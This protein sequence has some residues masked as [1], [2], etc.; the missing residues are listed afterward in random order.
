MATSVNPTPLAQQGKYSAVRPGE[1]E[2][3]NEPLYDS[4]T[5]AAAGTTAQYRLFSLPIGQSGKTF[6]DTNMELAGQLSAGIRFE[7]RAIELM[8][9]PGV[10]PSPA[11]TTP[12]TT[13]GQS[14][15]INDVWAIAKAGYLQF[16][17]LAKPYLRTGPLGNFPS[18]KRLDV[19][20]A[21]SD[22]TTAGATQMN[23]VAYAS[24]GG[25]QFQI[26]PVLLDPNMNFSVTLNFPSTTALPSTQDAKIF[27]FLRGIKTR[28]SQ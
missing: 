27:V 23:R 24:L 9:F 12:T 26:T 22:T 4:I 1:W 18:T 28:L 14:N 21:L 5:Y 25:Q 20:A 2:A 6:A 8:I 7:V 3:V 10:L 13:T 19:E 17:I 11:A 16:D 15:F